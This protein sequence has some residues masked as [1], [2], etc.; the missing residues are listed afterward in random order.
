MS[1]P[2]R[3]VSRGRR[4]LF[5]WLL[6]HLS[7]PRAASGGW[8]SQWTLPWADLRRPQITTAFRGGRTVAECTWQGTSPRGN[9]SWWHVVG[10]TRRPLARF[11]GA[12]FE[13][14]SLRLHGGAWS[15]PDPSSNGSPPP[16][17]R[18]GG[19]G[20]RRDGGSASSSRPPRSVDGGWSD[21]RTR[22]STSNRA[23][24]RRVHS[25]LE[26]PGDFAGTLGCGVWN[27]SSEVLVAPAPSLSWAESSPP[28]WAVSCLPRPSAPR[29]GAPR[30]G[31]S[32]F[33]WWLNGSLAATVSFPQTWQSPQI[34][35]LSRAAAP[36][37]GPGAEGFS[38]ARG[39][40]EWRTRAEEADG[41][42][43]TVRP[44]DEET[45]EDY[46]DSLARA[47][48]PPASGPR[49]RL[50][51]EWYEVDTATGRLLISE[52]AWLE[53]SL[54]VACAA[55]QHGRL[56]VATTMCRLRPLSRRA[57]PGSPRS[58]AVC[59]WSATAAAIGG[60]IFGILAATALLLSLHPLRRGSVRLR[61]SS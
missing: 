33:L 9:G 52:A 41:P 26:L 24:E 15:W 43:A 22:Q 59:A 12:A 2:C 11:E 14:M 58:A 30:S 32:A 36:S 35:S 1:R 16:S 46:G 51:R 53:G 25:W 45:E 57:S 40:P 7:G 61:N 31:P 17:Q 13:W 54:C 21:E 28:H 4:A 50:H 3:A 38:Y 6:V 27:S 49:A 20:P 37:E 44:W 34:I 55:F 47:A 10:Q 18:T 19:T 42:A 56:G 39:P 23:S 5:V 60:A 29:P 48:R 8:D